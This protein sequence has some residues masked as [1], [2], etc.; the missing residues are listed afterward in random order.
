MNVKKGFA[1]AIIGS[2]FWGTAGTVAEYIFTRTP[3]SPL[4]L[5][6]LRLLMAGLLLLVWYQLTS[7]Q[8]ILAIWRSRSATKALLLFAALGMLPS[9]L[10]YFM[11]IRYGNAATATV[12]QFLGP[13][14]IVIFL[15]LKRRHWPSVIE[16]S[17]VLIALIGTVLLVTDGRFDHLSLAPL[18]LIWGLI[19]ALA[20]AAYTLLPGRLVKDYDGRL[21]VGWAMF[22]GSIPML[23]FLFVTPVHHLSVPG[24][25][26]I[27]FV[28]IFGTMLSYLF[29][30]SSTK[31]I[32]PAITGML[33]SF[34]PLTATLLST[35]FLN[36]HLMALQIV[37]GLLIISTAF[38]NFF[39]K[40][41]Q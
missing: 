37:G 1:Y 39:K 14:F 7:K 25:A 21:V 8:S 18:A 40:E 9:Q 30:I 35:A 11:A 16:T 32:Q 10:A 29:Y 28:I 34:E 22:I 12:L 3:V 13:M 36:T 15:A 19:A 4:W 6:A 23:P 26:A 41:Q 27:G 38:V 31:Y 2:I 5:V 17:T 20:Q 24:L 33:S